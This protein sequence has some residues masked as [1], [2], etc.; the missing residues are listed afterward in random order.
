MELLQLMALGKKWISATRLIVFMRERMIRKL[1][2]KVS[3]HPA[4]IGY[5][6]DNET[7][8]YKNWSLTMQMQFV[9]HLKTKF[10][11]PEDMNR[12]YGFHYW[13]NSVNAWEDMPST[14]GTINGSLASEYAYF[15]R[16]QVTDYLIWQASIVSE[17]KRNDQFITQNFDMSWRNGSHSVQSGVDHFE[18]AEAV[19]I[20]G[21]DIYH[22]TQDELDGV[23]IGFGGDLARSMKQ[24]N[25]LVI[26]T[27]AQSILNS[28][29]QKL[30]Y[31]G[32]LRLQAFSHLASGAQMIGYWPWHAI[33]NSVETYWKGVLSH[34]MQPNPT[35]DEV[36]RISSE[37]AKLN[38]ELIGL[39]KDNKVAIY[40]S[41]E[42][43]SGLEQ[44]PF[45]DDVQYIDIVRK[46]YEILYK[47]NIESDFVDHS[48]KDLSRYKTIIVPPLYVASDSELARL[49]DFAKNGG[50]IIYLFKSGFTNENVQVRQ[51]MQPGKLREATGVSYQQFMNM[52]KISLTSSDL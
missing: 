28:V 3:E 36:T 33:H 20:A 39:K 29:H 30:A 18:S 1:M 27:Q 52:E 4:V 12:A 42:S 37:I 51:E 11:S 2:D 49:N 24:D 31:P 5:Q 17:Y 9:K 21:I 32:Q 38:D 45:S 34:D 46:T 48:S 7:K 6:F 40:F 8:N 13:S 41:N 10:D 35:F 19:E 22:D 47:N 43:I 25:Y 50:H 14:I 26:E 15:Q 23:M 16:L 44:F